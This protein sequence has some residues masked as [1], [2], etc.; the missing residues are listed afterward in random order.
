MTQVQCPNCGGF[1]TRK[2]REIRGASFWRWF[3][4]GVAAWG[5]GLLITMPIYLVQKIKQS[6]DP[7]YDYG[8][9]CAICGYAWLQRPGETLPPRVNPDLI[10][11][12]EARLRAEGEQRQAEEEV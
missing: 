6:G 3:W 10:R 1:K 11:K 5:F 8:Y 7:M 2:V 12:G 9:Q 4:T